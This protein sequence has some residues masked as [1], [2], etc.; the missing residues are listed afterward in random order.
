MVAIVGSLGLLPLIHLYGSSP[1]ENLLTSIAQVGA[2]LLVAFG[3]EISTFLRES[4]KRGG[5]RENWV[6]TA[7]GTGSSGLV[8][9]CLALALAGAGGPLTLL[10]RFL[11]SFS[12]LS[13]AMLGV[14]VALLPLAMHEWTHAIDADYRDE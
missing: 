8:G 3:I 10:E 11:F 2:T 14:V 4:R 12:I 7:A 9:I 5:D 13:I 1:S 6:G